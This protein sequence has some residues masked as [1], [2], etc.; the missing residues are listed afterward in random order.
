M[1]RLPSRRS[2]SFLILSLLAG[3]AAFWVDREPTQTRREQASAFTGGR[4]AGPHVFPSADVTVAQ[5]AVPGPAPAADWLRAVLPE[6]DH[7]IA[8]WRD[9]RPERIVLRLDD[10][11]Q[12]AF[13]VEHIEAASGRTVLTARLEGDPSDTHLA[14]SFLV[15]TSNASD[16]WDALAVFP[17]IEYRVTLRSGSAQVEESPSLA[18]PCAT[19]GTPTGTASVGDETPVSA[20]DNHTPLSVDVLFLYNQRALSERNQDTLRIDADSSNYIAASNAVLANSR[21]EAFRWRYLG[22]VAAPAYQDNDDTSVDLRA[23]RDAGEIAGFVRTTQR[24]YGADQAVLLVGGLKNDAVGRAWLGG[25][26][27]HSVVNYPWPT[28]NNGTRATTTTSYTT[29][30]HE[31][32]HNFGCQHQRNDSSTNATDGDG[33]FNHGFVFPR[34]PGETGTIMTVYVAPTVLSRIP[35]F[36]HPEINYEG[37]AIGVAAGQPRAAYNAR[38]MT[39]NASRMSA[40]ETT[41]TAPAITE[42]PQSLAAAVGARVTFSVTATGGEL[43]YAWTKDGVAISPQTSSFDIASATAASA[44]TYVVTVSNRLGSVT[45][46]PAVLTVSSSATVVPPASGSGASGGGGGSGGG[47]HELWVVAGLLAL[48]LVR[49]SRR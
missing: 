41:V 21:I 18:Y 16:R 12:V 30:C 11:L 26:L 24:S 43:T 29:T 49:R 36:S 44:G 5:P 2:A 6:V 31:L 34:S 15:S 23:M 47:A 8:D 35:Y 7:H 22:A 39:E 17:G 37:N 32:G 45:S 3:S 14:G 13:R 9:F 20:G 28:F 10:E 48:S 42:Q 1:A 33:R 38:V 25:A 46:N 40:L 19:D 4:A 27:G